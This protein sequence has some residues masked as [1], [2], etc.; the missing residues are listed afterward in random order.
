L[1]ISEFSSLP[2]SDVVDKIKRSPPKSE[3]SGLSSSQSTE[4]SSPQQKQHPLTFDPFDSSVQSS[5]SPDIFVSSLSQSSATSQN[6]NLSSAFD[7]F[8]PVIPSS[9]TQSYYDPFEAQ[10]TSAPPLARAIPP[11]THPCSPFDLFENSTSP[12]VEPTSSSP[13]D[14]FNSFDQFPQPAK[15]NATHFGILGSEECLPQQSGPF[16]Q[17]NPRAIST[18]SF[19]PF[20]PFADLP[21]PESSEIPGFASQHAAAPVPLNPFETDTYPVFTSSSPDP[22]FSLS[23]K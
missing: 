23:V 5:N 11:Q 4:R 2:E 20:D 14:V 16:P 19:Q 10:S 1:A 21:S 15:T 9:Q 12:V 6:Q 3:I 13:F 7:L 22:F 18:S 17:S 8:D